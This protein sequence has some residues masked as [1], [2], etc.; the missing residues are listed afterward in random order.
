MNR[1]M[2][3]VLQQKINTY[4]AITLVTVV[5]IFCSNMILHTARA[6][7]PIDGVIGKVFAMCN[8]FDSYASGEAD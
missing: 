4:L 2:H 8:D 6:S 3:T 7:S 1:S 5:G